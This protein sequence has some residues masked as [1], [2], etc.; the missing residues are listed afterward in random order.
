MPLNINDAAVS[1]PD[2]K[3]HTLSGSRCPNSCSLGLKTSSDERVRLNDKYQYRTVMLV[4]K[5]ECIG[6]CT[7]MGH[8]V[9]TL[10]E[11]M[12]NF[13]DFWVSE[14][15]CETE[16]LFVGSEKSR[17]LK[18]SQKGRRT[19]YRQLRNSSRQMCQKSERLR[20]TDSK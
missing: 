2:A 9:G 11:G 13:I 4:K 5:N 6:A 20:E 7:A 3:G 12:Q 1:P 14:Q 8:G 17:N 16:I 10:R 18:S 15:Q 19:Q